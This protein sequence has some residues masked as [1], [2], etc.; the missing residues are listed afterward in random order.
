MM[1][2]DLDLPNV[3]C[4]VAVSGGADSVALLRLA[5]DGDA[6]RRVLHLDHQTRPGTADDAAFV[7]R[8]CDQLGVECVVGR[9]AD[10]SNEPPTPAGHRLARL[11]FFAAHADGTAGVLLAHHARDNA[12]TVLLRLIRGSTA[13]GLQGMRPIQPYAGTHL[14]RPLLQVPPA[15]LR[16]YL[17]SIGQDWRE[18]P[19]NAKPTQRR[20]RHRG[21]ADR[22]AAELTDL[23]AACGEW[24]RVLYVNSPS[25]PEAVPISA[26]ADVPL[27]RQRLMVRTWLTLRGV[28]DVTP[29]VVERTR[30][31]LADAAVWTANLPGNRVLRSRRGLVT[32]EAAG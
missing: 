17:R 3:P 7:R 24:W 8:L 31:V 28:P 32:L 1:L 18:D 14:L 11:R 21:T 26:L 10:W 12:E 23:A 29:A 25:L 5:H 16:G 27:P 22:L 13:V 20:N 9:R 15:E 2:E 19:S 30:R 6:A 4:C